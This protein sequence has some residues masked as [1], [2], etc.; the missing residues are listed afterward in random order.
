MRD[1]RRWKHEARDDDVGR[2]IAVQIPAD[3][4]TDAIATRAVCETYR[5]E[6][7][8]RPRAYLGPRPEAAPSVASTHPA[9]AVPRQELCFEQEGGG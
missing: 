2:A 5:G 1:V 6:S 7:G 8:G 4:F 3:A 9:S